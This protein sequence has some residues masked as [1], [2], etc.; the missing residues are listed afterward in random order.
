M[1]KSLVSCCLVWVSLIAHGQTLSIRDYGASG[2]GKTLDT[3]AFQS[4]I[5]AA[6]AK[7][8]GTVLIPSGRFVTGTIRLYSNIEV[9]LS[10]GAVWLGSTDLAQY[11]T[12]HPHLI[13]AEKA[14]NIAITGTG[15]IDGQGYAF[16][17]TSTLIWTAR[18]RPL[19]WILLE[20]CH[21]IRIR[22][23]QL[24]DSPAH[25]LVLKECEDV[26]VDG[27]SIR[28]DM[29]SPNTDGIDITDSRN[30]MISNCYLEAGDDLICLKSQTKWVEYVTVTNCILISD[31]A[32]I[33]FGTGGYVGIRNSTFSN[34]AIHGTRYGIALFMIDG[35]THEHC[36]F[37]NITIRNSSRWP[38]NYPIFVDIYKRKPDSKIGRIKDMQFRGISI[39]TNGNILI[40]GQPGHPIEDL[41]LEDISMTLTGCADLAQY[42]QKP[43]GNKTLI[44]I[45]DL[46]DYAKVPANFTLA[47]IDGLRL[48]DITLRKGRKVTSCDRAAFWLKDI[49]NKDWGTVDLDTELSQEI[50]IAEEK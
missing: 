17:D 27:I 30:V 2:D 21:R 4:A 41:T 35:G 36:I 42:T 28:C 40:A 3:K 25:V 22:D 32:A 10:P 1:V 44:P 33:K 43:R 9:Q 49:Q 8:G 13:Y 26:V 50:K 39:Q 37:E 46:F 38:N 5:D 7:G 15:L 11:D 31:D 19:P 29:R 18:T 48:D 20:S 6:A 47:H 12:A 16:Y 23:I 45:T 34:I 24:K 14:D